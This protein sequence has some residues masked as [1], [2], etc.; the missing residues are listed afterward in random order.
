MDERKG[1]GAWK[2]ESWRKNQHKYNKKEKNNMIHRGVQ[3]LR[4]KADI[5]K[6]RYSSYGWKGIGEEALE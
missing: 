2:S 4:E 6:I 5:R 1:K 3:L